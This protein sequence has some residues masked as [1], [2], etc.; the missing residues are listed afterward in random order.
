MRTLYRYLKPYWRFVLLALFLAAR[1]SWLEPLYARSYEMHMGEVH[2]PGLDLYMVNEPALVRRILTRE[3]RLFPKSAQLVAAL[4]PLLGRGLLLAEGE[5]WARQRRMLQPA[6]SQ[7]SLDHL[8]PLM[9]D[10]CDAMLA[11]LADYLAT[12]S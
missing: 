2:L 5:E 1:R 4:R 10:A 9:R 3:A 6:F 8:F 11:R 7:A 12:A